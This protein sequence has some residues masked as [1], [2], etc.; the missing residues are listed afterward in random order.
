[1][2]WYGLM[3]VPHAALGGSPHDGDGYEDH[4]IGHFPQRIYRPMVLPIIILAVT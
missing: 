4:E 3:H 1:M 2:G